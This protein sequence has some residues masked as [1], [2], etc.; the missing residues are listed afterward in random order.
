[1]FEKKRLF[2]FAIEFCILW[3][4]FFLFLFFQMN[5]LIK[6]FILFLSQL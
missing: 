3:V 4:F 5:C 6:S 1:M 2:L